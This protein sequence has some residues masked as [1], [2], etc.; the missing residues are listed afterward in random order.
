MF[1]QSRIPTGTDP[2]NHMST[3]FEVVIGETF[4][5]IGVFPYVPRNEF[6][7]VKSDIPLSH[8]F[9]AKK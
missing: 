4:D 6:N 5:R 3:D 1:S 9:Y 7:S 2:Q 8:R